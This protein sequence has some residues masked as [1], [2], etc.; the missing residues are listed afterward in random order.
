MAAKADGKLSELREDKPS[1]KDKMPRLVV[2]IADSSSGAKPEE[3]TCTHYTRLCRLKA[4]CCLQFYAC[5]F[6]HDDVNNHEMDRHKVQEIQ[7][8]KCNT[9]QPVGKDCVSCAV[10]FGEYFCQICRLYDK[11]RDQFHCDKCGICRVGPRD[12]FYHCDKCCACLS[13]ELQGN[14]KCVENNSK[15][16]CPVCFEFL[17]TSR[18]GMQVLRCGHMMH[19]E[20]LKAC[21]NKGL[22][23]CP[24]C[25]ES[26][27]DMSDVW[28]HMDEAC[29]SVEIPEELK[30]I[31]LNILCQDCHKLCEQLFNTEGLKCIHCGSY[32]TTQA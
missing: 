24:L 30:S 21:Y 8:V 3:A 11:Y 15:S 1:D 22:Y 28:K 19:Q 5:R 9:I 14:H 13:K 16:C 23:Q 32:N 25:K 10:T 18:S 20:C 12:Q 6:C 2:P 27:L 26:V 17:H 29:A 7:C 31:K 4:V